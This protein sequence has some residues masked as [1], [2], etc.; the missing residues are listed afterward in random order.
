MIYDNNEI[1]DPSV[2]NS[3]IFIV[4]NLKIIIQ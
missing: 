2:S 4:I 1:I 3:I